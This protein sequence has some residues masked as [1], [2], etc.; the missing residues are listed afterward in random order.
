MRI[1]LYMKAGFRFQGKLADL[2]RLSHFAPPHSRDSRLEGW[3]TRMTYEKRVKTLQVLVGSHRSLRGSSKLSNIVGE[4]NRITASD[5]LPQGNGALLAV[6]HTTRALD[7]TLSEIVAF[8]GWKPRVPALGDYL[9]EF[10]KH[11][12]LSDDEKDLY[13]KSIVKKRNKYM[14]EAGAMPSKLEADKILSEMHACMSI[15]LGR[16]I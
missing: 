15:V 12:C 1:W 11:K 8:K 14:H 2:M 16:V 4:L 3:K 9:T 10:K 6:L 13:Q 7:T 5:K